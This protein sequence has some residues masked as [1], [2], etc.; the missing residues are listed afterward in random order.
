MPKPIVVSFDTPTNLA[1]SSARDFLDVVSF[2]VREKGTA[3]VS[4][5]GGSMGIA[6]L[7][8]VAQSSISQDID[9][10]KVHFWWS[11]ERFVA[12]DDDDRNS[13]Q[14]HNALLS[15]LSIPAEN[16][17]QM[18]STDEFSSAEEAA[19]SYA[20]ELARF[21]VDSA[22]T[23]VFDVTL[24]GM[25][26][27]GHIASLFPQ[28]DEILNRDEIALAIH[29]SPKPPADRVTLTLPVINHSERIWFLISGEDK[30]EA[31][32][33]LTQA[34]QLSSHEI[35]A[36][37]LQQTPAAGARGTSETL[38]RASRNALTQED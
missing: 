37:I 33:R 22:S 28:R 9:W 26:P 38:I 13:L 23:P 36:E 5:T 7:E 34:A 35:S 15:Q 29:D 20:Q 17:H 19:N 32:G 24:L 10:S 6:I 18:G 4:L 31:L 1:N 8:A 27:D 3:H 14:A 2:A 30:K 21:A 16:I 12:Q 25:G 11:D